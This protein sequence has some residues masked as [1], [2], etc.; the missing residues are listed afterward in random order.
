M[1]VIHCQKC[2]KVLLKLLE[3]QGKLRVEVKC[4]HCQLLHRVNGEPDTKIT[5][6]I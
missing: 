2:T 5:I 3:A 1:K 4:Q 6:E